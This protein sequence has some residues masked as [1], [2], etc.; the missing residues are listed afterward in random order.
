M[1]AQEC[2]QEAFLCIKYHWRFRAWICTFLQ[3]KL[4]WIWNISEI[5]L[6]IS[7]THASASYYSVRY[8]CWLVHCC[9]GFLS[10]FLSLWLILLFFFY[11]LFFD[12]SFFKDFIYIFLERGREGG[13]EGKKHQCVVARCVPPTGDLA[14]N[15]DICPNLGIEPATLW[16][17]GRHSATEPH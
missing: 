2:T 9:S 12:V 4:N 7:R 11:P 1:G 15:P 10:I 17:T 16:F 13:R 5:S 3:C 14:H 8:P 6:G